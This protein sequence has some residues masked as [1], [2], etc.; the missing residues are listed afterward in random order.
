MTEYE[1]R[2]LAAVPYTA[3]AVC[4][5]FLV[6]LNVVDRAPW[7]AMTLTV[8]GTLITVLGAAHNWY[9]YFKRTK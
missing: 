1:H 4:W 2:W 8:V 9:S 5:I 7:W 3:Y 6:V